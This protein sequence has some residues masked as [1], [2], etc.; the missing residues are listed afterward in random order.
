MCSGLLWEGGLM[1]N[2]VCGGDRGGRT[3]NVSLMITDMSLI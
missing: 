2:L 1:Y 3:P